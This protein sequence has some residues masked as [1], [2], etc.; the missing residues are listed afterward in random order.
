MSGFARAFEAEKIAAAIAS[1]RNA[2]TAIRET[3]GYSLEELSL[4]C[5]LSTAEIRD[6]EN[7]AAFESS[8]IRRIESALLL[9]E[10]TLTGI[11]TNAHGAATEGSSS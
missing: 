4:A 8:K 2:L 5:G 9:P 10:G 11:L 6:L 1:G 7:G 3:I